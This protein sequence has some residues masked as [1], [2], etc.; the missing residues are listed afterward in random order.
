MSSL[1]VICFSSLV[2]THIISIAEVGGETA[3][4]AVN[5]A[6]RLLRVNVFGTGD[7]IDFIPAFTLTLTLTLTLIFIAG[8]TV[9]VGI[10]YPQ[11]FEHPRRYGCSRLEEH[12]RL[13]LMHTIHGCR[14]EP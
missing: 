13:T 8:V 10:H 6:F 12:N 14:Q 3:P 4:D 7:R 1:S 2:H 5:N 11:P 9:Q